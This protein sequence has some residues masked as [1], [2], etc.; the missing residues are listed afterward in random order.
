MTCRRWA[1][2]VLLAAPLVAQD[3]TLEPTGTVSETNSDCTTSDAHTRTSDNSDLTFCD[4]GTGSGAESYNLLL[5]FD[6]PSSGPSTTTN[7]QAFQCR[8]EKSENSAGN[9]DPTF[10]MELYCNAAQ[11][12][13][14][15][16]H[17]V[18]GAYAEFTETFTFSDVSCASDGSDVELLVNV[19]RAGGSPGGRRSID[20]ADCDWDVT[21]A[22]GATEEMMVIG[23][24]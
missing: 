16:S 5:S 22:A 20:V 23:A 9:G 12:E 8:V 24:R 6:T 10:T 17:T 18:T 7:D 19:V 2:I 3:Q 14:G 15:G 21:H 11:V 1:W 13:A 4:G